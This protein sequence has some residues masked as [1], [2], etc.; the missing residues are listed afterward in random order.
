[1]KQIESLYLHFPFCR[2]LCNYCD[3]YKYKLDSFDQITNFQKK[4]LKNIDE[5]DSFLFENEFSLKNLK[6]FY[7]GGGTPSVWGKNGPGFV[8]KNILKRYG[9]NSELEFTLEIDPNNWVKEEIN[10]WIDMGVNRVSVGAQSF[11]S[12]F[13]E[14]MDR[15]HNRDDII[16]LLDYLENKKINYSV[17]LMLGLPNSKILKRDIEKEIIELN[18]FS[19]S[20]FS[21]YILKTRKNYPLNENLPDDSYIE[22]EYLK[23]CKTL[24]ELSFDHYEVS[25]FAKEGC[26]SKHNLKYWQSASVAALGASA[27]GLLVNEK[28]A[29]RYKAKAIGN[30]F[31]IEN[32]SEES[33]LIEKVYMALRSRLGFDFS[34]FDHRKMNLLL[35]KWSNL[36]YTKSL[37]DFHLV[38]N[39]K[40]FLMLDSIIDDLFKYDFI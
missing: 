4:L 12:K 11:D 16:L 25:N 17:D 10:D 33:F 8:E 7:I 26:E 38:L 35:D 24:K 20:H 13:T 5:H 27:T 14:I 28:G 9:Y 36:S 18:Q 23:V 2:H 15:N 37:D 21:V 34:I 6:T 30:S 1:M 32:L 29:V 19:P 39:A 40:G 3:F 22:N 31:S